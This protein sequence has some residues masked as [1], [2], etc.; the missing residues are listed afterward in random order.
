ME[1]LLERMSLNPAK[2]YGLEAGTLTE[3][4]AADIVIFDA[5]ASQIVGEYASKSSNSP[6]TGER[7]KGVVKYTIVDGAVA[8]KKDMEAAAANQPEG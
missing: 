5:E 2:L 3:G 4:A 8:Y 6:F 1:Q 7:L